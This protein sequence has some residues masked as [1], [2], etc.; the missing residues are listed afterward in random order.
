MGGGQEVSTFAD[1]SPPRS[2]SSASIRFCCSRT[3]CSSRSTSERRSDPC[4][5]TLPSVEEVE[6]LDE[7]FAIVCAPARGGSSN[8]S[9]AA[10][11]KKCALRELKVSISVF[12][13]LPSMERSHVKSEE[14]SPSATSC[15]LS[16]ARTARFPVRIQSN[17]HNVNL[18][19]RHYLITVLC[20]L[21][22]K[23][24]IEP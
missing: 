9:A 7:E 10:N 6:L 20:N 15:Q 1:L 24:E 17:L 16:P 21:R 4:V 2:A 19:H 23:S 22:S 13:F 12:P 14:L 8:R 3:N 5:E 11:D 18:F